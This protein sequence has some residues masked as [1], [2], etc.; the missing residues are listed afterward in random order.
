LIAVA[1]WATIQPPARCDDEPAADSPLVKLLKSGRIPEARQGAVVEMIGKR[2][3]AADLTFLFERAISLDGFSAPIRAKVLEALA[4]AA[5]NRQLA[6]L[7]DLDK[8]VPLIRPAPSAADMAL[9]RPAVRL[10]GLWKL[11]AG[12]GALQAIAASA[13]LNDV[14]RAEAL[15]AL[16]TIGGK[17]GRS[18]IDVL[19]GR[20]Q[21]IGT[22]LLAVAAL[23]M[24]DLE[25]AAGQ[26]TEILAQP[27][28]PTR[29]LA[30]LLAAFL[31]RQRGGEILAAAVSRRPP[32]ADAARLAL[33]AVYGLGRADPA[34]VAALSRAAGVSAESKP[35]SAGELNQLVGE[36]AAKGDP[37][38]GEQIFRRADLNCM[39]CHAVT[40]AGGDVGPDLSSLGQTSPPDYIINSIVEPDQAIKEPYHTLLVLTS[41]GQV[42][43]GI[44]T[45]KDEQRIVLK[46]ATGAPRVVPVATIEDQKPGGSLMPKGLVNL[47][48]RAEFVDLV[49]FLSELGKPGPYAIPA[50]PTIQRWRVLKTVPE[51]LVSAVPNRDQFREQVLRAGPELWGT[52]Y[53]KLAGS[54][55]LDELIS[56][57]GPAV[58]YL[59]GQITVT[60]DGAIR[61]QLDMAEGV[62]FWVDDEPANEG[63]RDVTRTLVTGDH[64][65]TLR[66]DLKARKA[67]EIKVEVDKPAGSAAAFTVIGGR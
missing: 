19:A 41:G 16:A 52:A 5:S 43:Q 6:P 22:R 2:G 61:I 42:F 33:R 67:R 32:P 66:V 8:L 49:R 50:T 60:I 1:A 12:A 48:T 30:P 17:V 40:K 34:L 53:A 20:D 58:L 62:R 57:N 51:G 37:A 36:V 64:A 27:A 7:R 21:P 56:A 45:D 11:E 4:E 35:L 28:A 9:E 39:S 65:I 55:P 47:M 10:A 23:A 46:E 24:L 14:L 44:V 15:D 26:A 59:Q 29:D 54:L 38:R 63:A 18:R 3:T 31:N 25:A 13:P